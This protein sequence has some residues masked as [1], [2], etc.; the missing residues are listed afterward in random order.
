[1]E[2]ALQYLSAR[3]REQPRVDRCR[4][5][6]PEL[7]EELVQRIVGTDQGFDGTVQLTAVISEGFG[8]LE[9]GFGASALGFVPEI[10][11]RGPH[12]KLCRA[13]RDAQ[14]ALAIAESLKLAVKRGKMLLR[15]AVAGAGAIRVLFPGGVERDRVGRAA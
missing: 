2:A 13:N 4:A 9:G 11:L 10:G 14:S 12:T 3:N 8:E 15:L 5:D 6:D 7:G 1:M